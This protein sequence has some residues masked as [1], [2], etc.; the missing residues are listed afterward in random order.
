MK[1][2]KASGLVLLLL[3]VGLLAACGD[4]SGGD[5]PPA[6]PFATT[7]VLPTGITEAENIQFFSET[8]WPIVNSE[9]CGDCHTQSGGKPFPFADP[10]LT[11]AYRTIVDNGKVNFGTPSDSRIVVKVVGGHHCWSGDCSSDA[12]DLLLAMEDW[13]ARIEAAGGSSSGG[14]EVGAGTLVSQTVDPRPAPLGDG[15]EDEGGARVLNNLIAFYRFDEY[16]PD[17]IITT[18]QD[19]SGVPPAMDIELEAGVALMESYGVDFSAGR[20]RAETN[21]SRKLYDHIGHPDLGTGQ[22][23]IEMWMAPANTNQ[24]ARMFAFS[25][26]FQLIQQEYQY[27]F[28]VRSLA[29][30]IPG[31]GSVGTLTTYDQDRDLQAGLQHT[32]VTYDR[33]N[34]MRVFVNGEYTDDVDANGGGLLWNWRED[35]RLE[36]G[37][38]GADGWYGKIKMLA[39]YKQVLSLEQIRQNWQAGVGLRLTLRFDISQFGGPGSAIEISLS[40]IDDQSYL[41]CQ[42][43]VITDNLGMKIRG[44]RIKANGTE[45]GVGQAFSRL[46]TIITS[47]RQQISPHCTMLANDSGP[48]SFQL[49][50]EGLSGWIDPIPD[51]DWGEIQYDYTGVEMPPTNGMRDFARVNETMALLTNVPTADSVIEATYLTLVQ[52]LPGSAD[53]RSFVSSNQVGIS[54][55]GFSYCNELVEDPAGRDVF[56]DQGPAPIEWSQLPADAFLNDVSEDRRLRVTGPLVD[57][58]V[59]DLSVQPAPGDV[60]NRLLT[61][62]D[63]LMVAK[64]ADCTDCGGGCNACTDQATKDI[65]KGVCTAVLA[66]GA[67]QMH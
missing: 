23:S 8:V 57:K 24:E 46:N 25:D 35:R 55:L 34:G 49:A 26:N 27:Q 44:L 62:M 28:R 31:N 20:A 13:I 66:S 63:D 2:R 59:G 54:K 21:G 41:L 60:E 15:V 65:V 56:F 50:F 36:L 18:A 38:T 3:S 67:A 48:E 5:R 19:T 51:V 16:D 37:S 64:A 47:N 30:N 4:Y 7:G 53:L 40:Q 39:I 52:Q 14:T 33:F 58:M 29:P 42:P 22:F 17:T 61:L 32:V 45:T 43:T 6:D 9:T 12:I 1:I 10:N 11:F